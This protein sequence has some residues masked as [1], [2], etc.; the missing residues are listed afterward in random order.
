[1]L[2]QPR[3]LLYTSCRAVWEDG[4]HFSAVPSETQILATHLP[5]QT[6]LPSSSPW[7]A[8]PPTS[9]PS[10][11]PLTPSP[12]A[13]RHHSTP[14]PFLP[15]LPE[16]GADVMRAGAGWKGKSRRAKAPCGHWH[17]GTWK[18]RYLTGTAT[19]TPTSLGPQ[20]K[21]MAWFHVPQELP[22]IAVY[23][24]EREE[25]TTKNMLLTAI[26]SSTWEQIHMWRGVSMIYNIYK[27][28][29]ESRDFRCKKL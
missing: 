16:L 19:K 12:I 28:L 23:V 24:C 6:H 2:C 4:S 20:W 13:I 26:N 14:L 5:N 8:K 3:G 11:C 7:E 25:M 9:F 21:P 27:C 29:K 18:K 10:L 22:R 1:M 17:C 15:W